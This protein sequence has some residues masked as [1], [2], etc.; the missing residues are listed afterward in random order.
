MKKT[1]IIS[2][3]S[4]VVSIVA[5]S[6]FAWR[7]TLIQVSSSVNDHAFDLLVEPGDTAY[8]IVSR[9]SKQST[10]V[11]PDI[12]LKVWLRLS[13]KFTQIQA[14]YYEIAVNSSFKSIFEQLINGDTKQFS[15]T[16][17]EGFRWRDWRR[18]IES[19][20]FLIQDLPDDRAL[21][22][23][24]QTV[25][26]FCQNTQQSLE[27][28]LLP[29]TYVVNYQSS[30][31]DLVKRAYRSMAVFVLDSFRTQYDDV[32]FKTPYETLIL[33]SIVEKE[34][35]LASER[36][37]ISGVFHNRLELN[38]RLQTDPTVIYGIGDSFDGNIT[39]KHL[40]TYT[41]YNTYRINGLPP[42]PIAMPAR[43]SITAA[44]RPDVT[45]MLYFV[46]K[47][48]GSHQFSRTLDEHNDAVRFYQLRKR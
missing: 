22:E 4:I 1:L 35:G 23:R 5:I 37:L 31:A 25:D 44:S 15:V 33:A 17:V 10:R 30:A 34:T 12:Y 43:A 6:L 24:M 39:R 9:V 26:N 19:Y 7:Y 27:G 3:I 18:Q 11:I 28:C 40:K 38:M 29:D 32:V 2:V 46:A 47:G 16:L 8:S 41:P 14:G 20:P 13:P 48:D 36:G 42:T 45:D 21:Y